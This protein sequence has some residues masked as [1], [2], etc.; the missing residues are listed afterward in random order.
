MTDDD[1]ASDTDQ[2]LVAVAAAPPPPPPQQ[3]TL[4]VADIDVSLERRSNDRCRAS[5][6]VAVVD[7]DGAPLRDVT[8]RGRFEAVGYDR[9]FT[10]RTDARG[11]AVLRSGWRR[12]CPSFSFEVLDLRRS[13]Y[14]YDPVS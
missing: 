4:H 3:L 7:Q 10:D 8:V 13:G 2:V 12:P 5:A 9:V 14:E 6:T 11:D 1:G